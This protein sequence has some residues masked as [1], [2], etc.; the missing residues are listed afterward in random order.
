VSHALTAGGELAPLDGDVLVEIAGRAV[1]TM[2]DV[3]DVLAEHQPGDTV[4]VTLKR[5]ADRRTV[6]VRLTERPVQ[7]VIR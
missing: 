1:R 4:D 7:A 5:G 3:D 2:D 6:P